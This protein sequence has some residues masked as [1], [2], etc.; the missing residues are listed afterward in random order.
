MTCC[1]SC[2]CCWCCCCW[3]WCWCWW[4]WYCG[5]SWLSPGRCWL[6]AAFPAGLT[7]GD[8][9]FFLFWS[10]EIFYCQHL[11]REFDTSKSE[12]GV[13]QF[14][15]WFIDLLMIK[16]VHTIP[17]TSYNPLAIVYSISIVGRDPWCYFDYY[18]VERREVINYGRVNIKYH[19]NFGKQKVSR[20]SVSVCRPGLT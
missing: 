19:G 4:C 8:L 12:L 7:A 20:L 18:A 3:W 10:S 6:K 17:G 16:V 1:C 13:S 14:T 5:N 2:W 11:E 9:I 15:V